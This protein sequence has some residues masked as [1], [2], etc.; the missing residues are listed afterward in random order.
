MEQVTICSAGT[1]HSAKVRH[2][3]AFAP[4]F[5]VPAYCLNVPVKRRYVQFLLHLCSV[6]L[7]LV[8]V[9]AVMAK[10]N[11]NHHQDEQFNV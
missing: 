2:R 3:T 5:F 8:S 7:N 4:F 9:L 1:R 10:R 6:T 11:Q